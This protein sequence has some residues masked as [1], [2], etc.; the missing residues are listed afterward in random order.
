M[1]STKKCNFCPQ[2]GSPNLDIQMHQE[3]N[4]STTVSKSK[5]IYKKKGHGC[6]WWLFIGSWWWMIDLMLW[7]FLTVPRLL[8]QIFKKKKYKAVSKGTATTTNNITYKSICLCKNCGYHWE[9]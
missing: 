3:N 2:C 9:F 7:F 5:T 6:L 8:F 1:N 4:G